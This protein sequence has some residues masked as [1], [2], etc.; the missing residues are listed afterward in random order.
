[1]EENLKS[2][3]EVLIQGP[4]KKNGSSSNRNSNAKIIGQEINSLT[5]G[6]LLAYMVCGVDD[7]SHQ[8]AGTNFSSY[9]NPIDNQE[10]LLS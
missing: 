2:L 10:L 1:M 9:E 4:Q 8:I 5:N 6:A 7:Q 3:I